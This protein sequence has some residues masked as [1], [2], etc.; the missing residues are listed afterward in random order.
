[1][2]TGSFSTLNAI[3]LDQRIG[4]QSTEPSAGELALLR[5]MFSLNSRLQYDP[6]FK[7]GQRQMAGAVE[8]RVAVL[9]EAR[10]SHC[11][12]YVPISIKKS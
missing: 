4:T 7:E 11:K 3:L 9:D 10:Q 12:R 5:S 6:A 8:H 1:M 2:L